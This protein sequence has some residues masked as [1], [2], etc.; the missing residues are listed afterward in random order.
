M[1]ELTRQ[2]VAARDGDRDALAAAIRKA[3]PDVWRL[4]AHLVGR[5]EADDVTQDVFLRAYRSLPGFRADAS[6]RTWLL[7]ITQ[8]ACADLVRRARRRR[9]LQ[10]RLVAHRNREVGAAAAD[11]GVGLDHLVAGLD[12][13][14]KLAFVL[15]QVIGCSYAEAAEVCDTA[16]GTIRSRVARARADLLVQVRAADTA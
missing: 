12:P 4:A 15:T 2:L 3:Q 5:D 1:D 7:A 6:G 8:R 16:V 13:E 10:D 11:G 9:R 14:R